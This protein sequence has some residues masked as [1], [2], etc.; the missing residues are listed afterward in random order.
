MT[1]AKDSSGEDTNEHLRAFYRRGL[2]QV[3]TLLEEEF[4]SEEARQHVYR[5][6]FKQNDVLPKRN[7]RPKPTTAFQADRIHRIHDGDEQTRQTLLQFS[8]M[9]AEYYDIGDDIIDGDVK[10]GHQREALVAIQFMMPVLARLLHRLGD[11]AVDYWTWEAMELVKA[12]LHEPGE[13]EKQTADGYLDLLEDQAILRSSITGLAAVVAD[14]DGEAIER[15]EQVGTTVHKLMQ[16]VTDLKQYGSDDDPS[17]AVR[18]FDKQSF[19]DQFQRL[20]NE[21]DE[22]LSVYP[23]KHASQMRSPWQ[24]DHMEKYPDETEDS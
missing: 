8:I 3:Q 9:V 1:T 24:D 15:A 5:L 19:S 11:A 20:K 16:F 14:A 7:L 4:D 22:T 6:A 2:E 21:L 17:N 23:D 13:E 12:A 18:V 10:P